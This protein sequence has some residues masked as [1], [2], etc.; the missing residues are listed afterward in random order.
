[1]AIVIMASR[2]R[3]GPV[4]GTGGDD[5]PEVIETEGAQAERERGAS[6]G[7]LAAASEQLFHPA[8]RWGNA[9][10]LLHASLFVGAVV[11]AQNYGHLLAQ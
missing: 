11:L 9:K 3:S 8:L 2:R 4:S 7:W 1:V 6:Q 10:V 5:A